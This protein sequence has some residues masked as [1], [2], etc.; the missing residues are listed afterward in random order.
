MLTYCATVADK[1]DELSRR[2]STPSTRDA[3]LSYSMTA[4][5]AAMDVTLANKMSSV[6]P[7]ILHVQLAAFYFSSNPSH[8]TFTKHYRC[9]YKIIQ[10]KRS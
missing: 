3:C 4:T 10:K 5:G 9:R 6:V 1:A 8:M 2:D 7:S